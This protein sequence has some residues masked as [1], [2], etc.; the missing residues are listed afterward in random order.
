MALSPA[1]PALAGPLACVDP[2][3]ITPAELAESMQQPAPG[4]SLTAHWAACIEQ[5]QA[6]DLTPA[7]RQALFTAADALQELRVA[8]CAL[9][10]AGRLLVRELEAMGS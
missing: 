9:A 2:L 4:D 5:A 1:S 8:E 3:D 7:A 6:L 10:V